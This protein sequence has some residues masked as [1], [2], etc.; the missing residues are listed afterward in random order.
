MTLPFPFF[1]TYYNRVYVI[2][3]GRLTFGTG[4]TSPAET[5]EELT[6]RPQIDPFFDNLNP[7]GIGNVFVKESS[8]R[9]VVT[10]SRVPEYLSNGS[11]SFQ[12]TLWADGRILFAYAGLTSDDA[13]VG[14]SPGD[15]PT[16]TESDFSTE[17]PFS[18]T[19]PV[20][21]FEEFDG[22]LPAEGEET[23]D[24]PF[25][26]DQKGILFIP[27]ASGGFEVQEVPIQVTTTTVV[28]TVVDEN[29]NPVEGA[30]VVT[31]TGHAGV[32]DADGIFSIPNVSPTLGNIQVSATATLDNQPLYGISAAITPVPI[33][34]TDVGVV[35]LAGSQFVSDFGDRLFQGD[36]EFDFVPF[37]QGFTFPFFGTTYT[38]AYVSSNGRV[39][40]QFGETEGNETVAEFDEQP[41]IAPLRLTRPCHPQWLTHPLN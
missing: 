32:T 41:Q 6:A 36:N 33:G 23:G 8:D 5:L 7:A 26:L 12:A 19:S 38:G 13:I 11:N 18:T 9:L 22:P 27:N 14:I 39:S 15:S 29:D 21:I 20:A 4:D 2:S 30:E 34:I 25:D 37:A 16:L 31:Q 1:G 40:F 17:L 35:T 3:N 10:W 28:G 24:D